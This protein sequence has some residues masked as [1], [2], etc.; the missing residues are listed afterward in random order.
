MLVLVK[1]RGKE[2]RYVAGTQAQEGD[3]IQSGALWIS[4]LKMWTNIRGTFSLLSVSYCSELLGRLLGYTQE[5]WLTLGQTLRTY[6]ISISHT[7]DLRS[8]LSGLNWVKPTDFLLYH[9]STH[10]TPDSMKTHQTLCILVTRVPTLGCNRHSCA[11]C[12]LFPH[13]PQGAL[14]IAQV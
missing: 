14:P 12:S 5:H 2:S 9:V 7:D 11:N 13:G 8:Q 3:L 6:S 4:S 1:C 10:P